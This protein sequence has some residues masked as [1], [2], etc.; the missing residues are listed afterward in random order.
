MSG[1]LLHPFFLHCPTPIYPTESHYMLGNSYL[2]W[3]WFF[4]SFF[5]SIFFFSS[6]GCFD[7]LD[8]EN[9][10]IR[11]CISTLTEVLVYVCFL[12]PQSLEMWYWYT[13]VCCMLFKF[14]EHTP[15]WLW[16]GNP[17]SLL[18]YYLEIL[19]VSLSEWWLSLSGRA[20]KNFSLNFRVYDLPNGEELRPKF[21]FTHPYTS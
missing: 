18:P 16:K 15:N 1:H 13:S 3:I 10:K 5:F 12:W 21:F 20:E 17:N 6:K 19:S 8:F 14:G 4:F 7:R 9:K 2:L 11:F